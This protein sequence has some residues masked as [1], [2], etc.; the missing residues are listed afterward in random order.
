VGDASWLDPLWALGEVFQGLGVGWIGGIAFLACGMAIF[1]L[2]SRA[3]WTEHRWF[4]VTAVVS[5]AA[6]FSVLILL[7]RNIWPRL[8]FGF[9]ILLLM[10][11]I[12]GIGV[13]LSRTSVRLQGFVAL[14]LIAAASMGTL[15]VWSV[16]AQDYPAAARTVLEM[17]SAGE[18][19]VTVGLAGFPYDRVYPH[20]FVQ[21]ET[22]VELNQLRSESQA[23]LVL[24]TFPLHLQ[25]RH[26]AI[27]RLL[28]DEGIEVAR[29]IGRVHGGD[30][31]LLRL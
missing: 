2:G 26:P 27:W 29:T 21:V 22:A 3:L 18:R 10:I 30:L 9:S 31:V 24:Y 13:V 19:I 1:A 5:P 7:Q 12:R 25:S 11:A 6:L 16:P 17:A 4:V 15:R 28:Q 23:L 14:V 8:F 20:P